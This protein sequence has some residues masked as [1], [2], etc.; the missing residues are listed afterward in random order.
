MSPDRDSHPRPCAG[1][2]RRDLLRI[3]GLASIGLSLPDLL[4]AESSSETPKIIP[5]ALARTGFGRA[6]SCIFIYLSGGPPQ[7]ETFDPKPEA[8][9]EIRGEFGSIRTAIPGVHFS[10]LLPKTAAIANRF[11]TIRSM[12]TDNNSHTASGYWMLTGQPH[13]AQAE[14]PASP[15]DWPSLAS[16]VSMLKPADR[17]PFTSVILPELVHNDNA[18]PAPGQ[19]GGFM[20]PVW[21]PLLFQCEPQ[22]PRFEIDGLRLPESVSLERLGDRSALLR[23]MDRD[24][25]AQASSDSVR[26]FHRLQEQAFDVV[27]SATARAALDLELESSKVRD[28]Y[29]RTKFGQS[30]LLARRL[31]E[32]GVRLVQVNWPR[33]PGDQMTGNPVWDTHKHNASRVKNVLCPQFD[34]TFSALVSDLEERG[35]LHETLV[36]ATGEFGRSPRINPEG[37][38][39]HWG[40]CFSLAVAGAGI[41]GGQVIGASDRIGGQPDTRPLRPPDLAATILHLLG[42]SPDAEFLDPLNRPRVVTQGGTVISELAGT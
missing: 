15:D 21:N 42:I 38:R 33:E 9:S 29:G 8:P 10:E 25:V 41:R 34:Q 17:S 11:A 35:L 40:N 37:G 22:L 3:G 5:A 1:W 23:G 28:R 19:S 13:T 30:V 12:C 18:P 32:S 36:V 20:G 7:H 4:R 24:F 2:S 27:H 14:V 31:V 6:K 26:A 39:D 16:V